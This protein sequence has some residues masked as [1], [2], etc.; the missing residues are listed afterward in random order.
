MFEIK[1]GMILM[2]SPINFI[3]HIGAPKTGTSS[4]QE[5]LRTNKKVLSEQNIKYLGLL[6]EEAYEK[7]YK[8]QNQSMLFE[9]NQ[10][11]N[12]NIKK[13]ELYDILS[14]TIKEA[15]KKQV[16]T[17]I[18]SNESFFM[19]RDVVFPVLKELESENKINLKVILFVRDY[20]KWSKSAYL[21][22][23][24]K[25]KIQLGKV[26]NYDSW[27]GQKVIYFYKEISEIQNKYAISL[28]VKNIESINDIVDSFLNIC[29]IDIN[30]I[31][32]AR[33]NDTPSNEEMFLRALYNNKFNEI[34][35]PSFFEKN[36]K[37]YIN[38]DED[39]SSYMNNLMPSK[40]SLE[41]IQEL[42]KEDNEKLNDLLVAQGEEVISPQKILEQNMEI[43]TS[44]ILRGLADLVLSQSIK[45]N[46][47]EEDMKN[48]KDIQQ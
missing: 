36:I 20:I 39:I 24:I 37:K 9:F 34:L 15:N 10:P 23:G 45:I 5:T 7:K 16:T 14:S 25:H 26:E 31:K 1:E 11:D 8:W 41:N 30:N 44:K 6:L 12:I 27:K 47:L 42:T 32:K 40:V 46:K 17:L 2:E 38:M 4:I 28:I 3:L 22:W 43:N 18:L 19:K 48:L 13:N 33:L 29:Q 35:L 21:Q